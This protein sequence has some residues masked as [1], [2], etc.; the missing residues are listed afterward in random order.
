MI[1]ELGFE[2]MKLNCLATNWK[3]EE[4]ALTKSKPYRMIKFRIFWIKVQLTATAPARKNPIRFLPKSQTTAS[5]SKASIN[6]PSMGPRMIAEGEIDFISAQT[7][8]A[9]SMMPVSRQSCM[10][11]I[12]KNT[13]IAARL[14]PA[15][16]IRILCKKLPT[17]ISNEAHTLPI[18]AAF[19]HLSLMD[20]LLC[21]LLSTPLMLCFFFSYT[22]KPC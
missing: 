11:E 1:S 16:G 10:N 2:L 6:I 21:G 4:A 7:M 22:I 14:V 8:P 18:M 3:N 9:R 20:R 12:N 5:S 13:L 15:N 17:T 19:I